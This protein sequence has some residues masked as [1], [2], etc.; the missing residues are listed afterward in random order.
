MSSSILTTADL[1]AATGY[2]RAAD[3]ERCL[4]T[5]GVRYMRGKD[6]PW[7]TVDLVN[8]ASGLRQNKAEADRYE[9]TI[10]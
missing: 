6:G 9:G 2:E 5:Q 3:I 4:R 8:A 10:L 1:K 7:T